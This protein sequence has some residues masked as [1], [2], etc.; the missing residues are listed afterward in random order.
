MLY[1][2]VYKRFALTALATLSAE[3][4]RDL[5]DRWMFVN[6]FEAGQLRLEPQTVR[7]IRI[8]DLKLN[9]ILVKID[10]EGGEL[11]ALRGM[12][13]T[14]KRSRPV[15]IIENGKQ[16]TTEIIKFLTGL[17]YDLTDLKTMRS[18]S[19]QRYPSFINHVF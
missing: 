7:C 17:D 6:N 14:L 13:E 8:D 16:R 18:Q 11:P 15:L 2:P 5:P 12:E 4:A 1:I 19:S 3:D 9:P 10:I